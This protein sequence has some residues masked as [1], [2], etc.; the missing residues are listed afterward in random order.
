MRERNFWG[1][2]PVMMRCHLGARTVVNLLPVAA[3]P[4]Y[5]SA[6]AISSVIVMSIAC[7][8]RMIDKMPG[9]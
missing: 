8:T 6:S 2:I 9:F 1:G 4:R 5:S 7:A 3:P